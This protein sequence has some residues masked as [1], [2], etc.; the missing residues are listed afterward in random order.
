ME[1]VSFGLWKLKSK[2]AKLKIKNGS[3]VL[4]TYLLTAS[5]KKREVNGRMIIINNFSLKRNVSQERFFPP[6]AF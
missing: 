3:C 2:N 6:K 1:A 4:R 5:P